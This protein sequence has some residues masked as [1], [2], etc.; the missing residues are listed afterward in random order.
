MPFDPAEKL[1]FPPQAETRPRFRGVEKIFF[2]KI[3][4]AQG[5]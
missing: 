3:L 5:K 2:L 1:G 4:L